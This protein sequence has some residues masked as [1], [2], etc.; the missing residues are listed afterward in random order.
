MVDLVVFLIAI[1]LVQFS[2]TELKRSG[3]K[4]VAQNNLRLLHMRVRLLVI[5]GKSFEGCASAG[6]GGIAGIY[7]H[8]L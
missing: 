1:G 3:A 4:L 6:L 5:D 2:I 7:D 8:A